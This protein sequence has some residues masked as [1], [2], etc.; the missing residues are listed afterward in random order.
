MDNR[1][2]SSLQLKKDF[3]S[4]YTTILRSKITPNCL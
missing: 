4:P 3:A 2:G 1:L